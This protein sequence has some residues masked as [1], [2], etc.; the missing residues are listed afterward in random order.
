MVLRVQGV[1][2]SGIEGVRSESSSSNPEVSQ[3]TDLDSGSFAAIVASATWL[4]INSEGMDY[5]WTVSGSDM[6]S[7]SPNMQHL[8]HLPCWYNCWCLTVI[9]V[10]AGAVKAI[11]FSMLI[12]LSLFFDVFFYH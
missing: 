1:W 9:V 10:V 3:R 5:L 12:L 7:M 6:N 8:L 4:Q 11:S 2:D